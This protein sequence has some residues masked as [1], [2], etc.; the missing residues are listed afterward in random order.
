MTMTL[1]VAQ[2]FLVNGIHDR[3]G[4]LGAGTGTQVGGS[5]RDCAIVP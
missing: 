2:P 4:C 1:E 5:S 3:H